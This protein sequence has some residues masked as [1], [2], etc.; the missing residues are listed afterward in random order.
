LI[1][2]D[3]STA[4]EVFAKSPLGERIASRVLREEL[5]APHLID[6]EFTSALRRLVLKGGLD[7]VIAGY[8]LERLRMWRIERHMHTLLVGRIWELRD[9]ISAYDAAYVALAEILGAPLVTCDAKLSRSHGHRAQVI[10]L[11]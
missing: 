6:I 3:A 10:L 8:A 5:H 1:V 2:L 11:Q 4:I 9:S 7:G